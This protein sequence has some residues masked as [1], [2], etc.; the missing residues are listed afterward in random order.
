MNMAKSQL[1]A[2]CGH[3]CYT[4]AALPV[5]VQCFICSYMQTRSLFCMFTNLACSPQITQ[6]HSACQ[7]KHTAYLLYA[8]FLLAVQ[9]PAPSQKAE[10]SGEG[11][12][13][14]P[15]QAAQPKGPRQPWWTG[16]MDRR[17]VGSFEPL[18]AWLKAQTRAG[19]M[20]PVDHFGN[21]H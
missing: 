8:D 3:P 11:R 18:A 10:P 15:Q 12:E 1:L 13:A 16:V 19:G 9:P 4:T 20:Q 21:E 2:R 5:A 14:A 7:H 6:D 17:F